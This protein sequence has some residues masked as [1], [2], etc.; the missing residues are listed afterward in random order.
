MEPL[1][2]SI[3]ITFL[4]ILTIQSAIGMPFEVLQIILGL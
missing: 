1:L 4:F 2:L 3:L